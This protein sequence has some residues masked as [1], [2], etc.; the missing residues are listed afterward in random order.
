M[1]DVAAE[2]LVPAFPR[3]G[4]YYGAWAI[5]PTAGAVLLER[6][7]RTDLARHVAESAPVPRPRAEV[8]TVQTA[9]GAVAVVML[10]GT[11][12]KAVSSLSDGTSTVAARQELRKAAAD[13]DVT[14]VLLAIDSPGGTVA[15]TMELAAEVRRAA[16]RKP[17]WAFI[18]DLGAS[19]AYWVASQADQ[20]FA[21]NRTALVGSIG[22]LAVVYDLSGAAEQ[23]GIKTLVFGTGPLKGAGA[24]GSVVTEDQQTYIRG[25]VEDAQ[26][27]FDAAVKKGRQ[28][29]DKQLTA[30]K[31]GGVFGATEAL[32][33]G[34][35]DGIRSFDQVMMDLA[36]ESRRRARQD[37]GTRAD[38]PTPKRSTKMGE[39]MTDTAG[40]VNAALDAGKTVVM[41]NGYTVGAADPV[42]LYRERM[43]AEAERIATIQTHCKDHPELAAQAIR[44]DWT[45]EKAENAVLRAKLANHVRAIPGG[46][47]QFHRGG[48]AVNGVTLNAAL[49]AGL[50]LSLG[51]KDVEKLYSADVLTAANDN[52]RRLGLQQLL[53]VAAAENGYAG[54]PGERLHPGNLREVLRH[55]F[56][57][58]G[59]S[60]GF[61]NAS[62]SGILSN[63]ANK[64]ILTGYMEE[65]NAWREISQVR[66]VNDLKQVTSY[67]ML[68]NMEYEELGAGGEIKHGTTGEESYTRQAK[69][70]AKMYAITL[71]QILND[72]LGAF[73]DIRNRVG[74]GAAKKLNKVFWT[75]FVNNTNDFTAA[76]TN[77]ISGATTTLLTDGVGLSLA[78]Q[79]FR[80]MTTPAADG[81]K[82]AGAGNTRPEILLVPPELEGAA[83]VLFRNQNLGAVSSAT[84]NIYAN[85][86]RPVVAWQL[87]DAGYTGNSAT[88]WYLFSAPTFLAPM[89]VSFLGGN[90]APTVESADADFNTLGIQIRGY[91][92]FGADFAEY[93][94]GLKSKG[95]A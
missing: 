65:D 31:T 88:A 69:L 49:E 81:T 79:Q 33:R 21:N 24:P 38:G 5:E 58:R 59:A 26:V 40:A 20:V 71:P 47:T 63:V 54:S 56:P 32:D 73:G 11:L 9:S 37:R 87:S 55:A 39:H 76:R 27:A 74:R 16:E 29:T 61:S 94:A 67:R 77:F 50:M 41:P 28:M 66:P 83:E 44:E 19:A 90:E 80:K 93:L 85:R 35:I 52:F 15:G 13:P 14:A 7:R 89:V 82:R 18:D 84:A 10:T 8:Q 23:A 12:Q 17:V 30:A 45:P 86:Y 78:V 95:S 68:D 42:A 91:H 64:E 72:D 92:A 25:I 62:V 34:L 4:D 60:T 6:V 3:A 2:L 36:A 22:T 53:L 70:Y 43:A 46:A 48:G 75:R 1:P 51:R 57:E